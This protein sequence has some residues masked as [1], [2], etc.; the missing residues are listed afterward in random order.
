LKLKRR[1][2]RTPYPY[3]ERRESRDR[4]PKTSRIGNGS[5]ES[6]DK[7]GSS[8]TRKS[9]HESH[10]KVNGRSGRRR[11]PSRCRRRQTLRGLLFIVIA[12]LLL[13]SCSYPDVLIED[14][15]YYSSNV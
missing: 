10:Q 12:F 7:N 1:G 5:A 14:Y 9:L 4:E 13:P 6:G 2:A 15:L 8:A 11:K 3:P